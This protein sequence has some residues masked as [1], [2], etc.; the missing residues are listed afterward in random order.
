MVSINGFIDCVGD[1]GHRHWL[2]F[3]TADFNPIFSNILELKQWFKILD[4]L[5]SELVSITKSFQSLLVNQRT[6]IAFDDV[7]LQRQ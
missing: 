6:L 2:L 4:Q 5:K 3:T 7:P 1:C